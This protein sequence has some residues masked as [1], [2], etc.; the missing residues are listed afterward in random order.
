MIELTFNT[1]FLLYLSLTLAIVLG[2]WIYSH[3]RTR[4]RTFFLLRR[5]CAF[6]NIAICLR[7]R[8][9]E[10]SESLPAMRPIQ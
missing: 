10:A 7:G 4:Q 3:Y 1:L 2:I 6:V 5:R 8:E 9:R